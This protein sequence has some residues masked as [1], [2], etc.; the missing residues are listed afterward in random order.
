MKTFYSHLDETN[1]RGGT[2]FLFR[3][4]Y[5]LKQV[6]NPQSADIIVF[7]GGADIGTV[8]YGEEPAD[9]GIPKMA[10][11]RDRQEIA[12]FEMFKDNPSK[13]LIGICRG[14]QLLNCLNGGKLWQDVNGHHSSHKMMDQRTGELLDIT[15]THHQQFRPTQAAII[16]GLSSESTAKRAQEGIKHFSKVI[17]DQLRDGKDV[18]IVFYEET[19]SLCI[20]GHPEYVPGSRF[21]DYTW[22]LI[23]E[24]FPRT[25]AAC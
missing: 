15:S 6:E 7:N 8:I 24:F 2:A 5:G 25:R 19:R 9:R 21:S 11:Q 4:T 3:E 18:E 14:G 13:L 17:P 12:L 23:N 10:S 16:V 20:Q 22:E 1:G